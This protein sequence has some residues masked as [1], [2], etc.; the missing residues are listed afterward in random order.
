MKAIWNFIKGTIISIWVV[1]AIFATICLIS[2]NKHGVSEFGDYSL[3]VMDNNSLKPTFLKY[4]IILVKKDLETDYNTNDYVFFYK[5]NRD[6]KSYLNYG[7]IIDVERNENAED[8]FIFHGD[9]KIS[10]GNVIGKG[11]GAIVMHKLGIVLN[12]L[13]SKWGFMFIIIL[14]TIYAVV[15]EIYAIA[16]EVKKQS[17]KELAKVDE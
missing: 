14:P 13:E 3:F 12:V 2:A 7:Q 9:T 8:N 16:I 11:N 15:Y 5:G 4:D 10:Y 17:K 6:I 1:L